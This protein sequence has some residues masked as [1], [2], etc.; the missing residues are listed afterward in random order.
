MFES[1]IAKGV[2]IVPLFENGPNGPPHFTR[3]NSRL[4]VGTTFDRHMLNV[5]VHQQRRVLLTFS[6][7]FQDP[8][9][10]DSSRET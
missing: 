7:R 10:L 1:N 3:R 8:K 6:L 5:R 4:W 9:G 2:F